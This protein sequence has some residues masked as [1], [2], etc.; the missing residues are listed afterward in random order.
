MLT[1]SAMF[2]QS[3]K[4][5][6]E[7]IS[8]SQAVI[9][10]TVDGI[11]LTANEN[12]LKTVGYALSEVRGCHHSMFVEPGQRDSAEYRAF[13]ASLKRGEFRSGEFGR[14]GKSGRQIWLQATYNPIMGFG[15]KPVKVVKF[16][17]DVTAIKT[18]QAN[19][20]GQISAIGKSQA[21]IEFN[22]DGTIIA[23]NEN[24]LNA[25]GYTLAEVQGRHHGMF[26][27][28]SYQRSAEYSAFWGALNRGEFSSGEYKR[29][30]KGGR[31]VWIQAT[32]NP[33]LDLNGRP[34]KVVKFASDV[35]AMKTQSADFAGQLS[36]ISKS[37]AVIEFKL[38]GTILNANENF[39]AAVGYSLAEIK[40]QHHGMFVDAVYRNSSEYRQFWESLGRGEYR[41]G[42]FQRVAKGDRTLWL[43]ASYNPIFDLNGKPFKVVKYASDITLEVAK[44][45]KFNILSLVADETDNSVVITNADGLIEYVNP[46]FTKMT[47]YTFDDVIGKKPG[48]ILQGQGTDPSTVG[49]IRQKLAARQPFYDE[50]LN[51]T[52][53]GEPY[54]ISLSINPVTD[55]RGN[56]TRFVSIQANVTETKT[57]ALE[58][59]A[60]MD[61]IRKS[62]AVAEWDVSGQLTL[63]NDL[64]S[65]LIGPGSGRNKLNDV[66]RLGHLLT[67]NEESKIA[68]GEQ[69]AKEL[70]ID[71]AAG[72]VVISAS[73]QPIRDYRGHIVSIV[74]Y[75]NDVSLRR[76]AKAE[77]EALMG[78]VLDR[79]S[80][81]AQEIDGIAG[82]TN[83]L[84]L[85]ATI[86]AARAGEAGRGFGVV[87][88]EVR[89]L[90]HRSSTSTGEIASLVTDTRHRIAE[91]SRVL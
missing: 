83:V 3:Y 28:E 56:I 41:A 19:F 48:R 66:M 60:R 49:R 27:E 54:W 26:V 36:A 78:S 38:D 43:Q 87:A 8:R 73:F 1:W 5:Q 24:F 61:A 45:D 63:V 15:G 6:V 4:A 53:A 16:A 13:W 42:E 32:Y 51:Y 70:E 31:E 21:V 82:Q 23:A 30:A 71:G 25:M 67:T 65:E 90:A 39:L 89:S 74:M 81:I 22:L 69:L 50:I 68:A 34:F 77:T 2:G 47:G 9:E 18:Q 44:R 40:N 35:T 72:K 33:I 14:V 7:A 29:I 80:G 91:L 52:K 17:N 64:L 75:G 76:R 59:N 10:F 58:F 85:N 55:D 62:N 46:G 88:D 11:I 79:I 12:F 86:E 20:A 57:K 37:Q 84:A